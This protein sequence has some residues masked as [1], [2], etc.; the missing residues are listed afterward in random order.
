LNNIHVKKDDLVLE[1]GSGANPLLRSDVLL[2]KYPIISKEHRTSLKKVAIDARPLVVGDAC[3][4][5]FADQSFDVV[6]AR[7]ILEHLPYPQRFLS[8]V[9]RV[10]KKLFIAT[11]S[12]FLEI[13]HGGYPDNALQSEK[14]K[15]LPHGR[16]T[17]GH[18][19]FVL[20]TDNKIIML[21]KSSALYPLYLLLGFFVRNNTHY[22]KSKFFRKNPKW[23]ETLFFTENVQDA[24]IAILTDLDAASRRTARNRRI[25]I[26][27]SSD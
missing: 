11:P 20:A 21:A 4:L 16:G 3:E 15:L 1:I 24:E 22:S 18:L 7:H 5:P 27:I 10:S 6:V 13:I 25:D 8:E 14:K 2:D 12:P 26:R 19:W 9:K 23:L 17:P